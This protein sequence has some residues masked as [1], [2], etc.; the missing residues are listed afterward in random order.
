MICLVQR[1]R[2]W[3]HPAV[4]VQTDGVN[5][6]QSALQKDLLNMQI[7]CTIENKDR[8]LFIIVNVNWSGGMG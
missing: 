8:Y 4:P 3:R 7:S 5:H 1:F 2:M 6:S